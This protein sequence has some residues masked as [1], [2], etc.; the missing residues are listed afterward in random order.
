MNYG[1]EFI[2]YHNKE[3]TAFKIIIID[4]IT[5]DYSSPFLNDDLYNHYTR[6]IGNL[7]KELEKALGNEG[8]YF[9]VLEHCYDLIVEKNFKIDRTKNIINIHFKNYFQTHSNDFEGMKFS[10]FLK[11]FSKYYTLKQYLKFLRENKKALFD[12]IDNKNIKE[13]FVIKY[14]KN[15]LHK[16]KKHPTEIQSD[17]ET[18]DLKQTEIQGNE[19]LSSIKLNEDEKLLLLHLLFMCNRN[20]SYKLNA[21]EFLS[22]MKLTKDVHNGKKLQD[23]Y[24]TDYKKIKNGLKY[25]KGNNSKIKLMLDQINEICGEYKLSVIKEY[26][27]SIYPN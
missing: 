24:G 11:I 9:I 1:E 12:Y 7:I 22:V 4:R 25:Y 5:E 10:S 18:K 6:F 19:K 26:I 21:V 23:F 16:L 2:K 17:P 15:D 27:R 14:K 13:F 20:I 3:F 8:V